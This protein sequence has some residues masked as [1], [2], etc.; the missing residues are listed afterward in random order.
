MGITQ[1]PVLLKPKPTLR[2]A[3]RE[4]I[5]RRRARK[6]LLDY[7]KAIDIPGS[8]LT[9]DEEEWRF[10]PVETGLASHHALLLSVMEKVILGEIPRAMFFMPPGSA[11]A[12]ALDTKIATPFGWKTMGSLKVGDQVFDEKGK[13]CNVT[14]KSEVF[15]NRPCFEVKTDCGDSIIADKDHEWL[16]RI[17]GKK[18][19]P[20][21]VDQDRADGRG[22]S[23]LWNRDDPMSQHKIKETWE[24]CKKRSKR[25]MVSRAKC[26]VCPESELE[27]DPYVL[28]VWLGDGESQGM[29]ITSDIKD[30][31]FLRAEFH[32]R[33]Y[34]TTD[35][36][37]DTNFGV[38]GV[39]DKF[40]SLGLLNGNKK[41][42][43]KHYLRASERQRLE[44]L[45][46]LIDSDGTVCRKRGCTTFCNVNKQLALQVRELVRTLGVKAG[47]SVSR[48]KIN[49]KD[50]GECYKVSFYLQ[51][52]AL[53][54][55]KSSLTRNQYRT[56]NTYIDVTKTANAD[57]VCIEVDS[58]SHLFLCGE[59]MTPTHNSTYGSVVAPTWAMGKFP[60]SK[61]ILT[62]YGSDLA[63]KHG[64]K[65]RQIVKSKKYTGI[66]S[67]NLSLDTAAAD[68]W[69]LD[70]GSEYMSGGIL[71]GITGN[72]ANGLIIDDPVRGREAA[73]SKTI[74]N[75]TW[76]A[77]QDDLRTRLV[78]GGWEIII[79]TRWSENDL[80]GRLLPDKYDGQTG[81]IE[82]KDGRQ[83]YIVC[84]PAQCER[85]DDPLGREVGEYLWPEWFTPEHFEGFKRIPRT[86]NAL[87][88]QR[89]A[90]ETGTFFQRDWFR[91]Y[92]EAPTKLNKYLTS[93]HAP[94]DK[95]DSDPSVAR[96]WGLDGLG[97]L[98]L[99][100]GFNHRETMDKTADKII[101]LIKK[102]KPFAWFPE[103][104]NNYKSAA[105]FIKRRMVEE[106][107]PCRIEPMS[108]HGHDKA[109][110]AQSFQG[111]A[112]MG[113]V[114][115][116]EGPEG[117]AVLDELVAFPTGAHDEE[118][119][120]GAII[121]RALM[122]AHP[123]IV[124]EEKPKKPKDRYFRREMEDEDE[125]DWK[126][127]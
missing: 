114:W 50:C 12:L 101:H 123:A 87:F 11:K 40:V 17:C 59:S 15:H 102:H 71:S 91:R 93:D 38:I 106:S 3:A 110:K 35:Q 19:K 25:P 89:P 5:R 115:L 81:L 36:S 75:K 27:V 8:P 33:G 47:W 1:K 42:I 46:G 43:P 67:T 23:S 82:C 124:K 51:G 86:W 62:S 122:E 55:R 76:E 103:D 70:N 39:R 77:Y 92:R 44:L 52:S 31:K 107:A 37:V 112:S 22:L 79:Q 10:S 21:V 56:P 99:L 120:N 32:R 104:D 20:L 54:P 119:D 49:E 30:Q 24:L 73:D 111:M 14:W 60:G 125:D 6:S 72:R 4:L 84:L 78:P 113:R 126:T 85:K 64:R 34:S 98:Y 108:P 105:P 26:L 13:P 127:I 97:D 45:Q 66:F 68:E 121:G 95:D 117:D 53:L 57:T 69:A 2:E 96:I 109:S 116:P 63:K 41:F 100:D 16:V 29:R 118:V 7:A 58:P 83:W 9:G 90:A 94:T 28:G 65:A 80:A 18:R 61:I 48:A 88:Q 74:C